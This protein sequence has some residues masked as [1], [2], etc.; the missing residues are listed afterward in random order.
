MNRWGK[1]TVLGSGEALWILGIELKADKVYIMHENASPYLVGSLTGNDKISYIKDLCA[2][3]KD[4]A[5]VL[6]NSSK[7][8]M[9]LYQML[10]SLDSLRL[11]G[12]GVFTGIL[13]SSQ[14][15]LVLNAFN[16][17]A[18][19]ILVASRNLEQ[20]FLQEV[21]GVVFSTF[22]LSIHDLGRFF[23]AQK[24]YLAYNDNDMDKTF[25]YLSRGCPQK[26]L[27]NHVYLRAVDLNC[28]DPQLLVDQIMKE[29]PSFRIAESLFKTAA[30]IINELGLLGLK[31]GVLEAKVD[32]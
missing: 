16:E 28:E 21:P 23:I 12:V 14:K 6:T 30:A 31:D 11:S 13:T 27:L 1:T 18:L 7:E 25:K 24:I 9:D 10:N 5:V 15:S 4:Q 22:P 3:L 29:N 19:K 17:G 8:A 20:H 2:S 32:P 26:D